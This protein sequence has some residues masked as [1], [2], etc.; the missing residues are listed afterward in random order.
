MGHFTGRRQTSAPSPFLIPEKTRGQTGALRTFFFFSKGKKG[1]GFFPKEMGSHSKNRTK[2]CISP[3]Y[4]FALYV[5]SVTTARGNV[6]FHPH[7]EAM[8]VMGAF[9]EGEGKMLLEGV[10]YCREEADSVGTGQS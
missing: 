5:N 10:R 8:S 6:T 4:I 1:N 7:G 3:D 9:G 2:C